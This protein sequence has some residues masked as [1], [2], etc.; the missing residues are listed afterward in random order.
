MSLTFAG[1]FSDAGA[2]WRRD[3]D[4]LMRVAG[5]Y[6]L[7]PAFATQLFLVPPDRTG[8]GEEEVA[9]QTFAWYGATLHWHLA[10]LLAGMFGSAVLLVLLLDP[11]RPTLAQAMARALRLLPGL[12]LA[13][14]GVLVL[15]VLGSMAFLIPGLYLVGRTWLTGA[16][17]VCEPG[18]GP[19]GAITGSIQRTRKRGWLLLAV[20]MTIFSATYLMAVIANVATLQLAALPVR[21]A[22]DA[23]QAA[24][25]AG[26]GVAQILLQVAAHRRLTPS[27]GI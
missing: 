2:L 7:L 3:R 16:V 25:A 1:V 13:S 22:I 14:A 6:F 15:V 5:V 18:R 24:V 23:L 12:L 26:A 8:L 9:A 27:N 4:I 19:I 17:L 10:N 11:A 21:T 20:A